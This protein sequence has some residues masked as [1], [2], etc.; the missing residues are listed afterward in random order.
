MPHPLHVA[1]YRSAPASDNQ[2]EPDAKSVDSN[3]EH[4]C[5]ETRNQDRPAF[6][7]RTRFCLRLFKSTAG[8][9]DALL[10]LGQC[11]P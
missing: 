7:E 10:L 2:P 11:V 3:A 9:V 4:T 6:Q 8:D 1:L 5:C